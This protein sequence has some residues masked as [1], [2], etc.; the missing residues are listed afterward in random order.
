MSM[1]GWR[2][3]IGRAAAGLLA[4]LA[5]ASPAEAAD[6]VLDRSSGFVVTAEVNGQTL[7][8]R[9]DPGANGVIVLNPAAAERAGL[10]ESPVNREM[11]RALGLGAAPRTGATGISSLD[12]MPTAAATGSRIADERDQVRPFVQLG[13]LLAQGR[14]GLGRVRIA[15]SSSAKVFAWFDNPVANEVDGLISPAELPYANITFRL[16]DERPRER[17]YA[18]AGQYAPLS[19]FTVPLAVRG[20]V[21]NVKLSVTEPNSIATAAA[22]AVIAQTHRGGWTGEVRRHHIALD[23]MRPVR[24]LALERALGV[25]GMRVSSFLVRIRDHGGDMRLP[26]DVATDPDEIVVTAPGQTQPVRFL[27]VLGRDRLASCSSLVW[28]R[29]QVRLVARCS[30]G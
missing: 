18:L 10:R 21:V 15:G 19:G 20:H 7:R 24:P 26:A 6:L 14:F 29:R 12:D 4:A 17:S 27:L 25:Q 16:A 23:V 13:P 5:A 22:A 28:Q 8:L 11:A 30:A 2:Q 3:R 1:A 9:V